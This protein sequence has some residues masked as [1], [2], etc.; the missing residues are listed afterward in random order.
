MK[1]IEESLRRNTENNKCP[2]GLK[3][4]CLEDIQ[5][6]QRK[7][8]FICYMYILLKHCDYQSL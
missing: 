2:H 3:Y 7:T 6:L 8:A 5:N 1:M 4:I